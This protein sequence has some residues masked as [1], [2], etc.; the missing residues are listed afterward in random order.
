MANVAASALTED[1]KAREEA[2]VWVSTE[3]ISAMLGVHRNT[4]LR[5]K[6]RD[7]LL[8]NEHWRKKNPLSDRSY[9]LWHPARTLKRMGAASR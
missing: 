8:E 6:R 9:L 1:E 2:A 4:V 7:F 5:L 3:K